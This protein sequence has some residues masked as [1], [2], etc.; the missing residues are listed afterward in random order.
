ML[1]T[2]GCAIAALDSPPTQ[3]V[4][5]QAEAYLKGEAGACT[6]IGGGKAPPD[7]AVLVNGSLVLYL[8]EW[9]REPLDLLMR[10]S[11]KAHNAEVH[12][13]PV[14]EAVLQVCREH[15]LERRIDEIGA[16]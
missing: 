12:T 13:Q 11:L 10:C 5:R 16:R 7:R 4:R 9:E 3:A 8:E 6:F 2:L 1:D 14:L 15:H